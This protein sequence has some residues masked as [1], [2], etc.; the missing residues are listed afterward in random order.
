MDSFRNT[1][2]LDF[3]PTDVRSFSAVEGDSVAIFFEKK[4]DS[5][6]LLVWNIGQEAFDVDAH[7]KGLLDLKNLPFV[8]QFDAET[9][10]FLEKKQL[11]FD[12]KKGQRTLT[13]YKKLDASYCL[14]SS[15]N[16]AESFNVDVKIRELIAPFFWDKNESKE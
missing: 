7:L 11:V 6:S 1:T 9:D 16:E 12:T 4:M 3:N 14:T 13:F 15:I 2:I 8:T 10:S 5:D